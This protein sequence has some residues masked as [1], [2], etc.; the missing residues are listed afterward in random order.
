MHWNDATVEQKLEHLLRKVNAIQEP[1]PNPFTQESPLDQI[2]RER[3]ADELEAQLHRQSKEF[4]K[5]KEETDQRIKDIM[6]HSNRMAAQMASLEK[7]V[8]QLK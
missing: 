1:L 3:R 4:E 2:D 5:Y 8:K 7:K 6:A